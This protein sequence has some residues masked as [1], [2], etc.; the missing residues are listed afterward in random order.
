MGKIAS[1]AFQLDDSGTPT[2]MLT[3]DG[4][5]VAVVTAVTDAVT[6]GKGVF[7]GTGT[8]G[9]NAAEWYG[10]A[11][12]ASAATNTAAIQSALNAGGLV[13]ITTPGTYS[14]VPAYSLLMPSNS[15]LYLAPGVT[16]LAAAGRAWPVIKNK[17]CANLI[18]GP[19]MVRA[20]NVV[21]VSEAGH[22]KAVGDKVFVGSASQSGN[23]TSFNGTQTVVSVVAGVS[24]TYASA[25]SNGSAGAATVFYKLIPVRR[26]LSGAA[27]TA[28]SFYVTVTDPGHDLLP[29]YNVCLSKDSA[30]NF[31]PGVVTVVKVSANTWTYQT[32]NAVGTDSGTINLSY[33]YNI[34]LDGGVING[35]RLNCATPVSGSN[36]QVCTTMFGCVSDI[37]VNSSLG[38]SLIRGVN[39]FNCASV[40]LDKDWQSFD[41]LVSAQFEGGANGVVVDQGIINNNSLQNATA[42]QA[43]DHL[44]FTGTQIN[45][46][47]GN[48]DAFGS[49]YGL[50]FF[51]GLDVRSVMM[52][53]ALNGVKLTAM[54]ASCP[55]VGTV[56]IGK[57]FA[58]LLDNNQL[59][60][61]AS[62]ICIF[63]D[64]SGLVA[65]QIESISI[66]GPIEWISQSTNAASVI[67]I[68]IAGVGTIGSMFVRNLLSETVSSG[69]LAAIR[70]SGMTINML[71]VSESKFVDLGGTSNAAIYMT[72][73]TVR[74]MKVS[75]SRCIP[76]NTNPTVY[77]AGST[78]NRL[79]FD[80]LQ[81]SG[82][83]AAAGILF[84]YGTAGTLGSL[85]FRSIRN[86][87]GG[88]ALA[89]LLR[90]DDIAV[91]TLDIAIDN[92]DVTSNSCLSNSGTGMT[93]TINVF[94]GP[95]V[96]WAPTAGNNFFQGGGGTWNIY[97]QSANNVTINAQKF[98][99]GFG[100]PTYKCVGPLSQALTS[101]AAPAWNLGIGNIATLATGANATVTLGAPTNIPP[102]GTPCSVVI[103]QDG[104][105]GRTVAWDAAYIF[106]T[107][108]SNTGNTANKKSVANFISDGSALVFVGSNSWY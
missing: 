38:G 8:A 30:S 29:R 76:G 2:H 70:M 11:P 103:T 32:T 43:D 75:S 50:N 55:F 10:A 5:Q 33:D 100:T 26:Q 31:A 108:W 107:A 98:L 4:Q 73:G 68:N 57:I 78:V 25:G 1:A 93:G 12:S 65:T 24:W 44:A 23:D 6:G 66:D 37:R 88:N 64:G 14:V 52:S 47:S 16:L 58:R 104:V 74:S 42:Q 79:L 86:L 84:R 67:G 92:L 40:T 61:P 89:N 102:A 105:G 96:R 36:I 91:G 99:T 71:S 3:G 13:T 63:D 83:A 87:P 94:L 20:S 81:V 56:K 19:Q 51:A 97:A 106:P 45:N 95:K 69:L 59:T 7:N 101:G 54:G 18:A 80:D 49:P 85:E 22:T 35:N 9:F 41:C 53:S 46:G 34:E 72:G 82:S 90:I 60:G 48:Y 28:T 17:Y 15:K 21:T 62:G 39:F 77:M 27:F